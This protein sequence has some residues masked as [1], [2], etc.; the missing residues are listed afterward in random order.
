MLTPIT[1]SL[2]KTNPKRKNRKD[3]KLP[4]KTFGAILFGISVFL[5]GTPALKAEPLI[6][7]ERE[8]KGSLKTGEPC[9]LTLQISWKKEEGNYRFSKPEPPLEGL[10]LDETGEASTTFEK[11]G[12]SWFQ[13]TFRYKM[14]AGQKGRARIGAFRVLYY[15]TEGSTEGAFDVQASEIKILPDHSR[16]YRLLSWAAVLLLPLA[17]A[18]YWSFQTKMRKRKLSE[19]VSPSPLEDQALSEV[20]ILKK[21]GGDAF[22]LGR[23]LGQYLRKK[24]SL[25]LPPSA[26]DRTLAADLK[27]KVNAEE[28]KTL[29]EIFDKLEQ[30]RFTAGKASEKDIQSLFQKVTGYLEGKRVIAV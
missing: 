12:T 4:T 10:I 8:P 15:H 13:K 9:L 7:V 22:A 29:M 5:S 6:L 28:M 16:F 1:K 30:F 26:T 24:Y 17:A 14:R 27:P 20:E 18:G 11:D 21:S 3:L 19:T 25:N 23:I 2:T